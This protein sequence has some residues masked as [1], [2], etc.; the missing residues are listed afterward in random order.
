MILFR[1]FALLDKD[2]PGPALYHR[3]P[4]Q[5]CVYLYLSQR[6]RRQ[7]ILAWI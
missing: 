7:S 5:A 6:S 1:F 2:L 3:T 4:H